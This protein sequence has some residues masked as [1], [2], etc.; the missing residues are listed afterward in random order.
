MQEQNLLH[1]HLFFL[2]VFRDRPRQA[3][4]AVAPLLFGED[5]EKKP[6][7]NRK[8]GSQ[9]QIKVLVDNYGSIVVASSSDKQVTLYEAATGN[10]ICKTSCGEITTAMCLSTNLKHLITATAEGIL[11]IWKIPDALQ[12]ALQRVSQEYKMK[13][14]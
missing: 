13:E 7:S 3:F 5:L 10:A 14:K 6:E 4:V 11:F 12:K 1:G 8:S 2:V 9:D